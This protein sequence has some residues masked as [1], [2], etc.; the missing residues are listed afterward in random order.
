LVVGESGRGVA[1]RP[2]AR[3]RQTVPAA[4]ATGNNYYYHI[5]ARGSKQRKRP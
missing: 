3:R 2:E 5:S 1:P 4:F